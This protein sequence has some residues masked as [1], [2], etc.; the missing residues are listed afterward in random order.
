[1]YI[2]KSIS[3]A[4]NVKYCYHPEAFQILKNYY[5]E[6]K[7]II[8]RKKMAKTPKNA[9]LI[10]LSIVAIKVVS[11]IH[12]Y[13]LKTDCPRANVSIIAISF[14]VSGFDNNGLRSKITKSA[15]LPGVIDPFLSSS[16]Y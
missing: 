4:F 8:G 14:I 5:E 1:M 12:Y 10:V 7:F 16:K 13:L 2:S 6:G 11:R 15:C 9:S 3:K